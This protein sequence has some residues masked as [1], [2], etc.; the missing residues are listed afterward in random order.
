MLQKGMKFNI[1]RFEIASAPESFPGIQQDRRT[2]KYFGW[3]E[4]LVWS[5]WGGILWAIAKCFQE[6]L[7]IYLLV[8]R[9]KY[10]R[11]RD[12]R[13]WVNCCRY[14]WAVGDWT[15]ENTVMYFCVC[16]YIWLRIKYVSSACMPGNSLFVYLIYNFFLN[17]LLYTNTYKYLQ[18]NK[19]IGNSSWLVR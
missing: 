16:F 11:K 17:T 4:P 12:S 5:T 14:W 8:F 9:P 6:V 15:N 10:R 1:V 2:N 18:W 3:G 7:R 19:A 13:E